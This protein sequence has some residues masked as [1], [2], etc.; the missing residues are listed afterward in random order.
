MQVAVRRHIPTDGL[1]A[2]EEF[3]YMSGDITAGV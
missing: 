3:E 1:G 2:A